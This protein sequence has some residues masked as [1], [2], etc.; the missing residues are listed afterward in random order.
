MAKITHK[1]HD[2]NTCGELPAVGSVAIPF[3]LLSK[4]LEEMTLDSFTGKKKILN[5]VPSFDTSTC[6]KSAKAFESSIPDNTVI[7]GISRDTPF[8]QARFCSAENIGK[9]I[10]LSDVSRTFGK[11]Y[12]IEIIDGKLAFF[13]ARAVIVIDENNTILYTELVSEI[14]NEP[15]YN[16]AYN[17]LK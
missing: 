6:S 14:G 1:G 3:T 10:F 12:G 16:K 13:L 2:I 17:A 9:S 4:T 7:L 5:V 8:A 11:D 15:D